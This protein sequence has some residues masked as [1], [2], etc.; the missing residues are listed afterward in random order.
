MT[1][2]NA[3][4][5]TEETVMR[6]LGIASI[7]LLLIAALVPTAQAQEYGVGETIVERRAGE[8]DR[9]RGDGDS[10]AVER[11]QRLDEPVALL[12]EQP[13]LRDEAVVK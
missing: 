10:A 2:V 4:P 9:P 5:R 7:C 12:A 11:L 6:T 8:T 3:L 1:M 13:V